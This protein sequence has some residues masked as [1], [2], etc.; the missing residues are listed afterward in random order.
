MKIYKKNKSPKYSLCTKRYIVNGVGDYHFTR[1]AF[2]H[3]K[4]KVGFAS[5]D[6]TGFLF[7]FKIYK[8]YQNMGYGTAALEYILTHFKITELSVLIDNEKAIHM[9]KKVGFR[10]TREFVCDDSVY[11]QMKLKKRW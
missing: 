2:Y 9:Y 7:N 4:L 5:I 8:K 6:D 3:N 1:I 11:Y 10:I